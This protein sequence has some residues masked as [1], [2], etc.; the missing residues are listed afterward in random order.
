MGVGG[1]SMDTSLVVVYS[2]AL[3]HEGVGVP[4]KIVVAA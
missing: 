4:D 3:V 1:E 2:L